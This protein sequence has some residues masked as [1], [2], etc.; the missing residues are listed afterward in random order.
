MRRLPRWVSTAG[1]PVPMPYPASACDERA[2]RHP[3]GL[4]AAAWIRR[5]SACVRPDRA[6]RGIGRLRP[7]RQSADRPA[8]RVDDA[9]R[10]MVGRPERGRDARARRHRSVHAPPA[11]A[12]RTPEAGA[13]VPRRGA[14]ALPHC[15]ARGHHRR[16]REPAR[17]GSRGRR[18]GDA[19]R[20]CRTP[21]RLRGGSQRARQGDAGALRARAGVL[22]DDRQGAPP[23]ARG[24]RSAQLGGAAARHRQAR[25]S[26]GDPQQG[27]SADGG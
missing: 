9:A 4:A 1:C 8:E 13:R 14:F 21:A 3:T 6:D 25:G 23:R 7:H 2:H 26:S 11:S 20:G 12:R 10:G 19:R 5:C 17:T 18:R 16:A 15:A 27:G 24:R 22:A